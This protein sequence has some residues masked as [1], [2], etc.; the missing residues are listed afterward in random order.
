MTPSE[1][2]NPLTLNMELIR[3]LQ[4]VVAPHIFTPPAV[5]DG[6]KNMF[7]RQKLP[8]TEGSMTV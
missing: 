3:H 1:Q 8:F 4:E 2:T 7:A 5:Y 6:R